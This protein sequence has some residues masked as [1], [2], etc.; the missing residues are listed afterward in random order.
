MNFEFNEEQLEFKAKCRKYAREVIR[1]VV[2]DA[3]GRCNAVALLGDERMIRSCC[4]AGALALAFL[5]VFFTFTG[6]RTD[7]GSLGGKATLLVGVIVI[8][9]ASMGKFGGCSLAARLSGLCWRESFSI[10]VMMNTRGLVDLVVLNTGY[11][12][13]IIPKRVFSIFVVMVLFSMYMTAPVLRR[14]IPAAVDCSAWTNDAAC[15]VPTLLASALGPR[16]HPAGSG[17][18]LAYQRASDICMIFSR[19][20]RFWST[21]CWSLR[22]PRLPLCK[23]RIC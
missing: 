2:D 13:G 16:C 12:L 11:D 8:L 4:V 3:G 6:L 17:T 5:P 23:L 18:C 14:L 10:G 1:R 9:V 19:N 20:A 15:R 7:I 22:K 21:R